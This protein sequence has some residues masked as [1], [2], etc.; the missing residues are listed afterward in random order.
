MYVCLCHNVTD[1]EIRHRV[2]TGEVSNMREL[3]E[4]L[5]VATQCGKCARCAKEV[6]QEA[7]CDLRNEMRNEGRRSIPILAA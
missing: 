7:V 1:T 2:R 3:R 6:L 4:Q 5:G